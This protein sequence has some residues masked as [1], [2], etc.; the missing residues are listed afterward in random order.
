[1]RGSACSISLPAAAVDRQR[2]THCRRFDRCPADPRAS[3]PGPSRR[4][5]DEPRRGARSDLW[6]RSSPL[7]R[8]P[9]RR[10]PASLAVSRDRCSRTADSPTAR[11]L[12]WRRPAPPRRGSP[13]ARDG[14]PA[15]AVLA[16]GGN[17][18]EARRQG[19]QAAH[20]EWRISPRMAPAG[21]QRHRAGGNQDRIDNGNGFHKRT[22]R[23]SVMF[24]FVT[25]SAAARHTLGP[26]ACEPTSREPAV[27]GRGGGLGGLPD[28]GRGTVTTS[29]RA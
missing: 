25:G 13:P 17:N 9:R 8:P 14:R 5:G 18:N 20:S 10:S 27:P 7:I 6:D 4:L 24:Q 15:T 23:P 21:P 3:R 28:A 11:K 19:G 29:E 1:M 26:V 16:A 22:F 12:N 2:S